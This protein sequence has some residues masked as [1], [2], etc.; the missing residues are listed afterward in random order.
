MKQVSKEYYTRP[1]ANYELISK[2]GKVYRKKRT[3][4][5]E[6]MAANL[7]GKRDNG[8]EIGD[9]IPVRCVRAEIDHTYSITISLC[10]CSG[11]G[12]RIHTTSDR[13]NHQVHV[14]EIP[15]DL[16]KTNSEATVLQFLRC[17]RPFHLDA[18]EMT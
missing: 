8:C 7:V 13:N 15:E 4:W 16:I 18:Q 6:S 3:Y 11:S 10:S 5:E 17:R 1:S 14:L 9:L 2:G 12:E